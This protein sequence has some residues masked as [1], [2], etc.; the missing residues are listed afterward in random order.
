LVWFY[1]N[2]IEHIHC[3]S[4]SAHNHNYLYSFTTKHS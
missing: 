2:N 1:Q 4:L 3:C